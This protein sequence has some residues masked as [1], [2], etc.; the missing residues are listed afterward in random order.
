MPRQTET[1]SQVNAFPHS[2][3]TQ[4]RARSRRRTSWRLARAGVIV[5][6]AGTLAALAVF[7]FTSTGGKEAFA[8]PPTCTPTLL[9]QPGPARPWEAQVNVS[10]Y[11]SVN[12]RNGNVFTA[13][14]I[15][16]WSGRG[17][18]M[19]MMLYHNSAA[20]ADTSFAQAVGFNLGPGWSMAYSDHLRL[21]ELPNKVTVVAANGTKNV[22]SWNSYHQRWY[23]PAGIHD[24]LTQDAENPWIWKLKH[25]DQSFHEFS[26]LVISNEDGIARLKRVVDATGNAALL[27]YDAVGTYPQLTP[28]LK[29]VL[30]GGRPLNFAFGEPGPD[31]GLLLDLVDPLEEPPCL[32]PPCPLHER[33][34]TLKYYLPGDFDAGWLSQ[35]GVKR[36]RESL[37]DV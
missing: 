8:V 5:F 19:N 26:T 31:A 36:G 27:S 30:A 35:L 23:P 37:I 28:R 11:S 21:N 24:E 16:S 20:V 9:P 13:I 25:K 7:L 34:W 33:R 15:V 12:T 32:Q 17:P 18:D 4:G 6:G 2:P 10:T 3:P 1:T 14:P 29:S 22:F